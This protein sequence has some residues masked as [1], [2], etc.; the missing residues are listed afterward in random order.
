MYWAFPGRKTFQ[1]LRELLWSGEYKK[2]NQIVRRIVRSLMNNSYRRNTLEFGLTTDSRGD[3]KIQENEDDEADT[4][5]KKLNRPYFEVLIID[6][7]S[8]HQEDLEL[9]NFRDIRRYNDAFIYE[10]RLYTLI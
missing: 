7:V 5:S 1:M 9:L 10:T 3:T 2:L 4:F 8:Q 6:N